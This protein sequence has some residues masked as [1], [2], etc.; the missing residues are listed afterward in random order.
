MAYIV[1]INWDAKDAVP[2]GTNHESKPFAS[3]REAWQYVK[4]V[5]ERAMLAQIQ[6]HNIFVWSNHLCVWCLCD[7]RKFGDPWPT[8]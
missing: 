8:W 5:K 4:R 1:T 2:F 7:P 3:K 6:L